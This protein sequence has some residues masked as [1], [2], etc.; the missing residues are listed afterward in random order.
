MSDDELID[1]NETAAEKRI[2]LAKGYLAQV[3]AKVEAGKPGLLWQPCGAWTDCV[4][5]GWT[6]TT[7][8]RRSTGS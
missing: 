1:A 7:T 8:P 6:T 2:R 3:Q 4:Q 5:S